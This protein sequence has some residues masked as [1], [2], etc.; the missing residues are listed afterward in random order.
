MTVSIT[1][2][3]VMRLRELAKLAPRR[4]KGKKPAV[5]TLIRYGTVGINGVR[6]ELLKV[7]SVWCSSPQALQRFYDRV[8]EASIPSAPPVPSPD[9]QFEP[10]G[11]Q[12]L[13]AQRL[14]QLGF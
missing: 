5:S 7:G 4:R 8:T 11:M 14:E 2:E 6:L 13:D 12:S 1:E 9:E 3:D 10:D